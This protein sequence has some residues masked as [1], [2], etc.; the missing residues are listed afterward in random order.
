MIAVP[1]DNT[2]LLALVAFVSAVATLIAVGRPRTRR[3]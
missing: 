1:A 2:D 3:S